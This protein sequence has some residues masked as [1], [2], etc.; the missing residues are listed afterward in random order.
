MR[1]WSSTYIYT[2]THSDS[3]MREEQRKIPVMPTHDVDE[4]ATCQAGGAIAAATVVMMLP[5][6]KM[7]AGNVF[8]TLH[9]YGPMNFSW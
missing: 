7:C 9:F 4:A 2:L 5:G 1:N 8:E 3:S 6:L